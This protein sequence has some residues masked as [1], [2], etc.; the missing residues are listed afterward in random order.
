MMNSW[1]I[2]VDDMISFLLS[3]TLVLTTL[4]VP[5]TLLLRRERFF[6][7]N[8]FTLLAILILSLVLPFCDIHAL[9]PG[10]SCPRKS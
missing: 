1:F 9:Y 2:F 7:Q 6:R 4:Y 8:R 5:Y 3:T 10:V